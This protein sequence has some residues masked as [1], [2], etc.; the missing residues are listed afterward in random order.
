MVLVSWAK[1]N[2]LIWLVVLNELV[3]KAKGPSAV[4]QTAQVVEK[5]I[6]NT[7]DILEVPRDALQETAPGKPKGKAGSTKQSN[8]E[9]SLGTL[10]EKAGKL[11]DG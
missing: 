5:L 3:F 10:L 7:G 4:A 9:E 1:K 2:S 11:F 6:R 8:G